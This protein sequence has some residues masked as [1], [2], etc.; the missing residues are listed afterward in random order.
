MPIAV[1]E[2]LEMPHLRLRLHSGAGALGRTVAWTHTTDLPE[3]WRWVAGGELL[4][5]NGM[6]IPRSASGQ[7]ELVRQLV[8]HGAAA[9]AIGER[10]YA[11]PLTKR[12]ARASEELGFP[13][14]WIAYPMPFVAISRAVA[15]ATLLEQ[16]QRLIRTERIYQALQQISSQTAGLRMLTSALSRELGC[17]IRVCDR[18]TGHDW[19]PGVAPLSAQIRTALTGRR[20]RLRA[21]V[22]AAPL[23]GDRR[24]LLV[25]VPTHPDAV[26]VAL[27]E[28]T[29]QPDALLMQHAATVCG[30]ALSQ[31]RL[32]I[33][34][35]RRTGAELLLQI[36]DAQ[37]APAVAGRQLAGLG[38]AL[39]EAVCVVARNDEPDLLRNVHLNLWRAAVGHATVHRGRGTSLTLLP[40]AAVPVLVQALGPGGQAG[41]S[42]LIA[43]ADRVIDAV[44]EAT[45]ALDTAGEEGVPLLRYAEADPLLGPRN[46]VEARA[47]ADRVLG[48]VLAL[49]SAQAGELLTTLRTFLEEGRS[50]QRTAAALHV[51]RQTV[52]YRV[53]RVEELTGKRVADTG[54]LAALWLAVK[55]I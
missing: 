3:P 49:P 21:G 18:A 23:E 20:G 43:R 52:R 24:V 33:E 35:D 17:E 2:L 10:M 4:M 36:L 12:L 47:L 14:L 30:L 45:W 31:A 46:P 9:L 16:S 37:L 5:T 15:E 55:A 6:P 1:G 38:L 22:V 48:R 42:D 29:E 25:D 11:P 26:L 51:H 53:R 54:D 32:T 28:P 34:H 50:W 13:V 7:E 44:R 27:P 40:D 39:E 41:V 8:E 19:Y